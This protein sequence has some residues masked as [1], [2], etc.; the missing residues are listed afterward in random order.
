M[1]G[2][3]RRTGP[4]CSRWPRP[5]LGRGG[6]QQRPGAQLRGLKDL[7]GVRL[8]QPCSV[9]GERQPAQPAG[10]VPGRA[11]VLLL[12]VRCEP[13]PQ[14]P[15]QLVPTPGTNQ[16]SH[17]APSQVS[18]T[19]GGLS[20]TADDAAASTNRQRTCRRHAR[21]SRRY[22]CCADPPTHRPAHPAMLAVASPAQSLSH[23]RQ[24]TSEPDH[25]QTLLVAHR[26]P[27][28]RLPC[29]APRPR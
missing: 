27:G 10:G 16:V 4:R 17:P 28:R 13:H 21:R 23:D 24:P 20:A 18:R 7:F 29:A 26:N 19:T 5:G 14:R 12:G 1:L 9:G 8:V 11:L 2:R 6:Q 22:R 25:P 15:R 3:A